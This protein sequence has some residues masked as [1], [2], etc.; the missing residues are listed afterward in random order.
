M[1]DEQRLGEAD[2]REPV[3]VLSPDDPVASARKFIE[4][5]YTNGVDRTLHHHAGEFYT[6]D[7]ARYPVADVAAIRAQL[8]AF[9]DAAVRSTKD[10]KTSPFQPNTNK[11][12]NV[13]D[14]LK[15]AAN[16][17]STVTAPAWL[18]DEHV[19]DLT[20]PPHEI[21]ACDNGLLH[22]PSL[23]L[24]AHTPLFFSRNALDYGF[25]PDVPDPEA[26]LRFLDDLWA[27][28]AQAVGILQEMFGHLLTTDTRQQKMFLLVGPKRSGKGTIARVL[29]A[30]LGPAN[31]C[32]PT[33]N[34]LG[35]NF[36]LA[37]LIG[38]TAAI[39]SDARLGGRADQ[40][41]IAE[42]LLSVSG[43]DLLTIDRKYLPS[44]N[45]KLSARFVLLSNEL[46]RIADASGALASRFIILT[47]TESFYGREDPDLTDKLLREMPGILNWAIAGW[48]RLAERGHFVQ[49]ASSVEAMHELENLGS[50]IGAFIRDRCI[51]APG[52]EVA[53]ADLFGAWQSWCTDHGR[54]H[55]GTS[56]S[57]GRDLRAAV[58]GLKIQQPRTDAGRVRKYQGVGL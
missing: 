28:D 4:T 31:I 6:W 43:E 1:K 58:P 29:A 11:V 19:P 21:L 16:L 55:P 20:L 38:K 10:G 18:T 27:N 42:R 26:W 9:L 51:V 17:P 53:C 32:A 57:F 8:Y 49:P 25:D 33:L 40:H 23:A 56:Q 24:L 36:G 2:V 48:Q 54:E 35:S 14:A 15:A 30:L 52:E 7:G 12:N 41:A 5:S 3:I 47:M 34:S 45:G 39:I 13:L 37:D 46:P 44:W 50:P 22:L